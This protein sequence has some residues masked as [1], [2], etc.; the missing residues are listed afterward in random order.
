MDRVARTVGVTKPSLYRQF[1]DKASLFL[2]SLRRYGQTDG[3]KALAAFHAEPDI[4][5]AVAAFLEAAVHASTAEGR[6][7]GC[8]LA[9]VASGQAGRSVEVRKFFGGALVSLAEAL[10][11]RF[12]AETKAGRLSDAVSAEVRGRLLV[13]IV[14]GIAIRARAGFPRG[15]LLRDAR[16][17]VR[18]VLAGESS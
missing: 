10:S 7:T 13:D 9:C 15:E 11:A 12:E 3:A 14:Q 6:P 1:G 2:Q 17:Y 16:S 18:I 4:A 8:L 5:A